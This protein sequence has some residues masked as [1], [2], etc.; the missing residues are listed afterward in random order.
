MTK[1][2]RQSARAAARGNTGGSLAFRPYACHLPR[3]RDVT[4]FLPIYG[5]WRRRDFTS[6]LAGEVGPRSGPGGELESRARGAASPWVL[7]SREMG[8]DFTSPLAGEVGPRSGPGG[9][10]ES[11][12]GGAVSPWVLPI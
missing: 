4:K 5:R 12:A 7:Q 3:L 10:L 6:P 2:S 9:E 8:P 1:G 11:R